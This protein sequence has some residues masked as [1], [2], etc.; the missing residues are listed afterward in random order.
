MIVR[1]ITAG[2]AG[3]ALAGTAFAAAPAMAKQNTTTLALDKGLVTALS[4]GG[5]AVS[6]T[7][8]AKLKGTTITFPAKLAGTEVT[9]KGGISF[10]SAASVVTLVNLAVNTK[11]GKVSAEATEPVPA[12]LTDLM[13]VSGGKNTIKKNGKWKNAKLSLAKSFDFGGQPTDPAVL[14]GTLLGL[15]SGAVKTGQ[16]I[17][18]INI[19]VKK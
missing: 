19:E 12:P 13:K 7:T 11:N 9:H 5:V 4:G 16:V 14:I 15:P 2:A 17:G 1:R 6:A 8:P 3:L 18:K 10:K